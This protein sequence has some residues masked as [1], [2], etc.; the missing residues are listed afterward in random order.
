MRAE[1]SDIGNRS[2]IKQL[3]RDSYLKWMYSRVNAFCVIGEN[4][5]RHLLKRGVPEEKM[6]RSPYTVDTDLFEKQVKKFKR[7]KCRKN[8]GLAGKD[9]IVL[10][11]GKMISRKEPLLLLRAA[12]KLA[13]HENFKV[14]ML[15][16]GPLKKEAMELAEKVL[17]GR[18]SFPG[19]VNQ[20][21][22]GRYYAASDLFV[23]PS[24]HETWGLVVNEA[25]QFG[26]PVIVSDQVG[27]RHDLIN[28]KT[29]GFV[30]PSGNEKILAD[31]IK[32]FYLNAVLKTEFA[33]GSKKLI[34]HFLVRHSAKGICQAVQSALQSDAKL[35]RRVM[36]IEKN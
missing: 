32:T 15:G 25:M 13:G 22:L 2:P 18:V 4:A 21:E 26:L 35:H 11:S 8:L 12:G 20:S 28:P 17:P 16:E 1:F 7:S 19:F 27:C 34:S 31:Q 3:I 6:V 33:R 24:N 29:T 23:L 5:R 36:R 9:F 10:F 14:I 30:F